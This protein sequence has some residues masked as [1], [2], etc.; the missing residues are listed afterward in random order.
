[1]WYI[2]RFFYLMNL[3]IKVREAYFALYLIQ[4]G[5]H[6]TLFQ[7]TQKHT[8]EKKIMINL[9]IQTILISFYVDA[10]TKNRLKFSSIALNK[11]N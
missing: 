7:R 8:Y 1:M 2:L 5:K 6:S 4:R 9:N 10:A 11:T 3:E